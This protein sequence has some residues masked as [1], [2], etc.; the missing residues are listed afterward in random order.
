MTLFSVSGRA[1][2]TDVKVKASA[3]AGTEIVVGVA[4][5]RSELSD[6]ERSAL[7][8]YHG[9]YVEVALAAVKREDPMNRPMDQE[10]ARVQREHGQPERMRPGPEENCLDCGKVIGE[11]LEAGFHVPFQG[12]PSPLCGACVGKRQEAEAEEDDE[13]DGDEVD[14]TDP[15]SQSW[16]VDGAHWC[17]F[18]TGGV[19]EEHDCGT[20]SEAPQAEKP[21]WM[22]IADGED[23]DA[24]GHVGEHAG[25]PGDLDEPI[26]DRP[27]PERDP[28]DVMVATT[29]IRRKR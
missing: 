13:D 21:D 15:A 12:P 9:S 20:V 23:E 19:C 28:A 18:P 22:K 7:M 6:E 29:P 26:G 10:L 24:D 4:F 3:S 27:L 2:V 1:R 17:A 14:T 5:R 8:D 11:D 16:C 25:S